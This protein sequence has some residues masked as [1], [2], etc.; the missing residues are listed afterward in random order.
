MVEPMSPRL[1]SASASGPADF[2]ALKVSS[3]AATPVDPD[4][5]YKATW[6]LRIAAAPAIASTTVS[7]KDR[8]PSAV[9]SSPQASSNAGCGSIP[10]HSGPE[11]CMAERSRSPNG[12]GLGIARCVEV[13]VVHLQAG[14]VP[15]VFAQGVDRLHRSIEL[16]HGGDHRGAN[17]GRS[18]AD[19][20][21]V[22]TCVRA[23]RGVQDQPDLAIDD[24]IDDGLATFVQLA[25]HLGRDAVAAQ[26]FCGAAGGDDLEALVSKVLDRKHDRTLVAV[27]DR[28]EDLAGGWQRVV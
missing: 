10:T 6:G 8:T 28:D 16:C 7:E 15:F 18:G 26:Y 3:T 2:A 17:R 23:R 19:F 12:M 22:A 21:A 4:R 14:D 5:S 25:D 27:G 9:S 1:A 11:A 13:R 20:V 24:Q